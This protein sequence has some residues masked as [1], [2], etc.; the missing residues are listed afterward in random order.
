MARRAT[1]DGWQQRFIRPIEA[2]GK[3]LHTLR[4]AGD[5]ITKLPKKVHDAPE[6][7]SAMKYLLQAVEHPAALM[8][9]EIAVRRAMSKD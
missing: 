3:T 8:F 2:K 9:A 1:K 7:Q 4:D 6:W 5:Y